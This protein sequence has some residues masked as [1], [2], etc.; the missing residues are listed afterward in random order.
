MDTLVQP[1]NA[2]LTRVKPAAACGA[3]ARA[4]RLPANGLQGSF[5]FH[6]RQ[7]IR[8]VAARVLLVWLFALGV[9][10]VNACALEPGVA[11]GTSTATHDGPEHGT[12]TGSHHDHAPGAHDHAPPHGSK[13][14][15][16]K[17]CD[18][19]TTTSQTT[20]QQ[21]DP[22]DTIFL[23]PLPSIGVALK[24]ATQ[25]AQLPAVEPDRWRPGIPILIAYLRLAL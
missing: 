20:K 5:M 22:F 18:E 21:V 19:P 14:P 2:Q 3:Y 1:R 10:I 8:R 23:A 17:F 24:P 15:C 6:R 7:D 11:Y 9:G 16:V 4:N 12:A 25:L 13:A